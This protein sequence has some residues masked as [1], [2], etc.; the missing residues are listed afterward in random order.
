M[1]E[2][3]TFHTNPTLLNSDKRRRPYW[4]AYNTREYRRNLGRRGMERRHRFVIEPSLHAGVLTNE[5]RGR[6]KP[7]L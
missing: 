1:S 3:T 7:A 4:L 5:G 2:L 6:G